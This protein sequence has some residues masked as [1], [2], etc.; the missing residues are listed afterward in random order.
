MSRIYS[1][2][3]LSR[4]FDVTPRALRFY[5]SKGLLNPA[6]RGATRQ[7]S[8]R[9]RTRL[10]LTLRGRRLGFKLEE[11]R[12]IIDMH[13]SSRPDDVRQLLRLCEKINEH[14]VKLFSKLRDVEETLVEMDRVEAN[15]LAEIRARLASAVG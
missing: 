15:C 13:D 12:E 6:R 5:E 14:R 10:R 11:C 8:E 3:Q 2:R 9:D 4:E 7:Y 1:I